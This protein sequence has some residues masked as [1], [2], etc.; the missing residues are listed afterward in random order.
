M[1]YSMYHLPRVHVHLTSND[2]INGAS[3][4][5]PSRTLSYAATRYFRAKRGHNNDLV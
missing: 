5:E 1:L 4:E 2:W 3:V